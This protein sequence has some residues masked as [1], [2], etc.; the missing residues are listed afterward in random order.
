VRFNSAI[1]AR[2]SATVRARVSSSFITSL[3]KL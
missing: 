3:Q 2:F 1:S